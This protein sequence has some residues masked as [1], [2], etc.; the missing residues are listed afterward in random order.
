MRDP[1]FA[2]DVRWREQHAELRR[3]G[4]ALFAEL[5]DAATLLSGVGKL[6]RGEGDAADGLPP[7]LASAVEA[8]L[9]RR[10]VRALGALFAIGRC[11]AIEA[12]SGA[13]S[14][15]RVQVAA[16]RLHRSPSWVL[17]A[18]EVEVLALLAQCEPALREVWLTAFETEPPLRPRA[19]GPPAAVEVF[20]PQGRWTIDSPFDLWNDR[21]A[22][23]ALVF[24]GAYAPQTVLRE[25]NADRW[26]RAVDR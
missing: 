4:A 13:P 11:L 20:R 18:F 22:G 6:L 15:E 21:D 16:E 2:D 17:E 9:E 26:F 1:R 19:A 25:A 24:V 7:E 23:A 10:E 14:A 12:L 8:F 5:G 3:R